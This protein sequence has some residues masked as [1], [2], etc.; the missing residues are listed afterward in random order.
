VT[1]RDVSDP[2]RAMSTPSFRRHASVDVQSAPGAK[3]EITDVP[4]A[5]AASMA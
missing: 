1:V 5:M 4:P 3:P 2:F